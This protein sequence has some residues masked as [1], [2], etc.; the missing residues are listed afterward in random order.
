M[1]VEDVHAVSK[2]VVE[3]NRVREY[4][5]L[6]LVSCLI[7]LICFVIFMQQII[8]LILNVGGG[9]VAGAILPMLFFVDEHSTNRLV[10]TWGIVLIS[11]SALIGAVL[12]GIGY[13]QLFISNKSSCNDENR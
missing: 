12:S 4:L 13:Y 3:K 10:P 5:F 2:M 8:K 7:W 1:R 6:V 11:I 9:G